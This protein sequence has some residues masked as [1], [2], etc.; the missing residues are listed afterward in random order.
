MK[1]LEIARKDLLRSLRSAVFIVFGFVVPLLV[2]AL[3]YFA[4]GGLASSGGFDLPSTPLQV[5]NLDEPD[6]RLGGWSAGAAL[7]EVLAS[8]DLAGLFAVTTAT[9]AAAARAAVDRQEAGAAVIIPAGLSAALS[10]PG[11]PAAI[12]LYQDPTLTLGPRIAESI[13]R[14]F[15]D[16]FAGIQIIARVVT[17]Q[18]AARGAT[19]GQ[20]LGQEAALEYGRWAAALG[21]SQGRGRDPLLETRLPSGAEGPR[22]QRTSIVS[23]VMAGMMVFYLFFTGAVSS[24]A[25][26]LEEESGTLARLFTT[27]TRASA[28]LGGRLVANVSTLTVQ[29]VL[30]VALSALVFGIR[31]GPPLAVALVIL[32]L[33]VLA[34]SFGLFLTSLL[35]SSRQGGAIYGGLLTVTG[36]LGMISIFG[37]VAPASSR[38][39]LAIVGLTVPQGWGVRGWQ[40]LLEGAGLAE[41]LPTVAVMLALGAVFFA[42]GVLRFRRRFA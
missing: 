30:L 11:R 27:P 1:T 34:T 33:V 9:D 16:G 42:I 25:L 14:Q 8:P 10:E 17:A 7:A 29:A 28:V 31:W 4:F 24:Q 2:T 37:A 3:F 12:E 39:V 21:E 23:L 13:V 22:D 35:K 5:V 38:G 32:G 15:V 20:A 18:L 19:G 41:V 6:A 36:M 40:Q 26:L